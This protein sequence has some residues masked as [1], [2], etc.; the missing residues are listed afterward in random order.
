MNIDSLV[1]TNERIILRHPHAARLKRDHTDYSYSD[2]EGVQLDKGVMRSTL[3][4]KLKRKGESLELGKLP[5]PHA[6]K[7]YGIIRENVGRFQ[8]PFSTGY[9]NAPKDPK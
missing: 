7:G 2:I 3:K 8:A 9:E 6:E 1:V 5:T 4:L